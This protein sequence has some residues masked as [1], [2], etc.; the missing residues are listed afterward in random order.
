VNATTRLIEQDVKRMQAKLDKLYIEID[1]CRSSVERVKLVVSMNNL[2]KSIES[3][4]D[5]VG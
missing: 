5:L 2:K 3:S 4:M 1:D